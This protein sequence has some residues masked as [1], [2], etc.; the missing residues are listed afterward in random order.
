[1]LCRLVVS[2]VVE[3]DRAQDGTLGLYIRGKRADAVIGRRH[4]F[5]LCPKC[6]PQHKRMEGE[7]TNK[8]VEKL[9]SCTY[10]CGRLD[11]SILAHRVKQKN[12]RARTNKSRD[13]N[14]AAGPATPPH[15]REVPV[16]ALAAEA[17]IGR[18]RPDSIRH[19]DEHRICRK[20]SA[21]RVYGRC[22]EELILRRRCALA[23]IHQQSKV[24]FAERNRGGGRNARATIAQIA[25]GQVPRQFH[26]R[27]IAGC[28]WLPAV[29]Q[30]L[31][32]R[33]RFRELTFS[34]IAVRGN[35]KTFTACAETVDEKSSL[36]KAL[37]NQSGSVF[38]GR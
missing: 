22:S 32:E 21:P 27:E 13:K 31:Q 4:R 23:A 9:C 8:I 7:V 20:P 6:L 5:V 15:V 35:R 17:A 18:F 2:E 11:K 26:P 19:K 37:E 24:S 34:Q 16:I 33:S 14:N 38:Q 25:S 29:T 30:Q 10:L 36:W 3:Q 28:R 1:M 12:I